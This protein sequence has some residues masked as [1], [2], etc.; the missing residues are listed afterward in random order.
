MQTATLAVLDAGVP[1]LG[2]RTL[3]GRRQTRLRVAYS[4]WSFVL[5][6]LRVYSNCQPVGIVAFLEELGHCPSTP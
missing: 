3:V 2:F 4:S 6:H 5:L 1:R